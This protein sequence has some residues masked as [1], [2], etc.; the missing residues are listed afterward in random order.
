[1][2]KQRTDVSGG[3]WDIPLPVP[4]MSLRAL[5]NGARVFFYMANERG[6]QIAAHRNKEGNYSVYLRVFLSKN[7]H[8][9]VEFSGYGSSRKEAF[10]N[11]RQYIEKQRLGLRKIYRLQVVKKKLTRGKTVL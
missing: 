4:G 1:M 5:D 11:L 8:S 6:F 3:G 10:A 7:L 2:K 9:S